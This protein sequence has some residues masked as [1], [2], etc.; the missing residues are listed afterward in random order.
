MLRT[1]R[2]W[3]YD[4]GELQPIPYALCPPFPF[5]DLYTWLRRRKLREAIKFL[6]E[7]TQIVKPWIILSFS[8]L[9]TSAVTA[10]FLHSNGITKFPCSLQVIIVLTISLKVM[11]VSPK[12]P[13]SI[14]PIGST[15]TTVLTRGL[16]VS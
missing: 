8:K 2:S 13:A 6:H 12:S 7:Y 14:R 15:G 3:E 1:L 4:F 5:V 11:L 10:T 9:V 16:H